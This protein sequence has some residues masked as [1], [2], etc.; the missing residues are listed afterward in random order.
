MEEYLHNFYLDKSEPNKSCLLAL[1]S[2]ILRRD[3]HMMETTKYGMPC[4]CYKNKACCY[5]WVDKKNA[6]P[7]I[8]FVEG[9][10]LAHPELEVGD[11]SRMKILRI[12][13]NQDIAIDTVTEILDD[14][15]ELYR[16]GTI[17]TKG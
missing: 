9:N 10:L 2:I 17:K 3:A 1:R 12:D 6:E 15:L 8:L 7:Y 11:R 14:A 5:L 13:P 4:F 16:N